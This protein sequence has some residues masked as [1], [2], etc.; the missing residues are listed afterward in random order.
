MRAGSDWHDAGR[1][2]LVGQLPQEHDEIQLT[3]GPG[4]VKDDFEAG[5][6]RAFLYPELDCRLAERSGVQKPVT[7][8]R[9]AADAL[10]VATSR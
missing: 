5:S 4:L 7:V 8:C 3:M 6:Q 2:A 1:S 9:S 10:A